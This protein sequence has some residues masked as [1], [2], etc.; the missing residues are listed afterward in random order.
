MT[1]YDYL[2]DTLLDKVENLYAF[3]SVF[4]FDKWMGNA[5]SRQSIFF[6]A[7]LIAPGYQAPDAA[8]R[9]GFVALMIDNGFVFDGPHWT[10]SES[11]AQGLYF[12]HRVYANVRGLESFEPYLE[13]IRN[14]P[15][16]VVD[17]AV[18]S[19]PSSWLDGDEDALTDLLE[20]LLRRR[21][22][23]ADLIEAC[24]ADR[25]EPFPA[26]NQKK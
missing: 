5:D 14:F 3:L 12:R 9:E 2:P 1:V 6:R 19:I 20:R 26:W 7:R 24:Q 23:V 11:A 22:R 10:F 17:A 8:P 16:E 18:R 15:E 21:N 25:S 13:R 4:V